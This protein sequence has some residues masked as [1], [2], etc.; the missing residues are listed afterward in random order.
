MRIPP[1]WA[2]A[3]YT[4]KDQKAKIRSFS[5]WGWLSKTIKKVKTWAK[6]NPDRS[7]RMYRTCAGLRLLFTDHLYDPTS[8]E[9]DDFLKSLGSDLLYRKLTEK[10]ECFRTRLTAKPWRYDCYTP[11]NKYPWDSKAEEQIYREWEQE[12]KSKT[13]KYATCMLI[14]TV[15]TGIKEKSIENIVKLH[16]RYV[17]YNAGAVLA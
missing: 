4:G 13:R 9:T 12:Y 2:K 11:P 15:G 3:A 1:Y 10:Q 14:D 5:A 8:K 17:F 6:Q 7:F 16:E